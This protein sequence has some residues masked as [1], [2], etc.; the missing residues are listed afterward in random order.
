MNK[1]SLPGHLGSFRGQSDPVDEDFFQVCMGLGQMTD[2]QLAKML[3]VL[4]ASEFPLVRI[5]RS[6]T[7]LAG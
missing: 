6:P 7:R 1:L 5:H 2:A 3:K 4:Q